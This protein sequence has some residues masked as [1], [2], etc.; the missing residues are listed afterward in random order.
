MV[1]T[2]GGIEEGND[3]ARF[4]TNP[5]RLP[6]V[7]IPKSL[8]GIRWSGSEGTISVMRWISIELGPKST[9]TNPEV[10]SPRES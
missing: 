2:D 5:L 10:T 7:L 9:A 6:P 1:G 4:V 8:I 3:E